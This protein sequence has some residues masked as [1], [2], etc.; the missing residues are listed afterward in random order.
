MIVLDADTLGV[1]RLWG[2][3]G[4]TPDDKDPGP[5][6]PRG[7]ASAT[8]WRSPEMA[9]VSKRIGAPTGQLLPSCGRSEALL[10]G[11]TD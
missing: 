5:C 8:A 4:N 2:A 10:Y 9:L 1:K 7:A 6:R 3:N 11:F